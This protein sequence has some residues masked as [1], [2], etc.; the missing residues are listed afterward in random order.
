M[1]RCLPKPVSDPLSDY[2]KAIGM[3]TRERE[4]LLQK[5][6]AN[7]VA[8]YLNYR[9]DLGANKLSPIEL[10]DS[11]KKALKLSINLMRDKGRLNALKGSVLGTADAIYGKCPMCGISRVSAIDHYLPKSIYPEFSIYVFNLIPIC[12][13]CNELKTNLCQNNSPHEFF[14]SY[15]DDEPKYPLI[16]ARIET[17]PDLIIRYVVN[18]PR[19]ENDHLTRA[20]ARQFEILKLE[21]NFVAEGIRELHEQYDAFLRV[22][23][24]EG[25]RG[26][27]ELLEAMSKRSE[28]LWGHNH[29]KTALYFGLVRSHEFGIG[30]FKRLL[31]STS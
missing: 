4:K 28:K 7:V 21:E 19:S 29:W 31:R 8:A 15:L 5:V 25:S 30:G 3:G 23:N 16:Y 17:Y 12:P 18:P 14:H 6:E 1:L 11:E 24:C 20:F 9:S 10:S 2:V 22:F 26:L 27:I 13:R